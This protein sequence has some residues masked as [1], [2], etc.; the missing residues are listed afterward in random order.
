MNNQL[1]VKPPPSSS[2]PSHAS[3]D[4]KI[5]VDDAPIALPISEKETDGILKDY[6]LGNVADSE[7]KTHVSMIKP[8]R[9]MDIADLNVFYDCYQ[10]VVNRD[11]VADGI[12]SGIA[13]CPDI[14]TSVVVDVDIKVK[15][16]EYDQLCGGAMS[17]N[18]GSDSD[19]YDIEDVKALIGIYIHTLREIVPE[20][21]E[22]SFVAVYL[23]KDPYPIDGCYKNGFHIQFPNI[24][25]PR[26]KQE[27]YLLPRIKEKVKNTKIFSNFKCEEVIDDTVIRNP[28]L[29]YKSRKSASMSPY[30]AESVYIPVKID[31]G[32][33]SKLTG[34]D[35]YKSI[36]VKKPITDLR[37]LCK[38]YDMNM[39]EIKFDK[40]KKIEYYLPRIL[41]INPMGR[42]TLELKP[43]LDN[44][45][46]VC[47]KS[48]DKI[49][50]NPH[51]KR[52][53]KENYDIAR[54]LVPL[55]SRERAIDY[56]K[57]MQVGWALYNIGEGS[58]EFYNLWCQFSKKAESYDESVCYVNWTKMGPR[59][60]T[61]GTLLYYAKY[62]NPEGFKKWQQNQYKES[63]EQSLTAYGHF[64]IAQILWNLD[65]NN[66]V[67]SP[68][69]KKWFYYSDGIWS[70]D[71]E[72]MS[73][74]SK[75]S[76][77]VFDIYKSKNIA[78]GTRMSNESLRDMGNKQV[79][80]VKIMSRLKDSSF[81]VGI[82]KAARELYC[83][84]NFSDELDKNKYL[85]AFK[86]GD[87]YDLKE[88][89]LRKSI[90][91]DLISKCIPH[92]YTEFD[93]DSPEILWIERFLDT[94]FPN[95]AIRKYFMDT[96]CD[97]VQ[98]GNTYKIVGIWSGDGNNGKSIMAKMLEICLG[99]LSVKLPTSIIS[100]KRTQSS[101]A[102][103]E[104]ARIG[105]GVRLCAVQEPERGIYMNTGVVKELSGNDR[106]YARGLFKDGK[107]IDP[108]FNFIIICN[109]L[110]RLENGGDKAIW[111]RM[112]VYPF[113]SIFSTNA[114][115]TYEEQVAAKH[116]PIDEEL[117]EKLSTYAPAFMYH[118]IKHRK[119]RIDAGSKLYTPPD[120]LTATE[121][122]KKNNDSI[123]QFVDE[124]ILKTTDSKYKLSLTEAYEEFQRW[125]K[126]TFP[127]GRICNK[128]DFADHCVNLMGKMTSTRK[129]NRHR[130]KTE[131][132]RIKKEMEE[133]ERM[134]GNGNSDIIPSTTGADSY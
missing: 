134:N 83:H 95:P 75:I 113:E 37:I 101:S 85:L 48:V 106:F 16:T 120:V 18:T 131:Q 32:I 114:P 69:D 35:K 126:N 41:S 55:L 102:T 119:K 15:G 10:D 91:D 30:I 4:T 9:R 112:R 127:N 43:D 84:R 71:A 26:I 76:T 11:V 62:D 36:I 122:Y 128:N 23:R 52:T 6:I 115:A 121:A 45:N 12:V 98:G 57:W 123:R 21:T 47:M 27:I 64:D 88:N 87:V 3:I 80:C 116:F 132:D 89:R 29:M 103:P 42:P 92:P 1:S 68:D 63:V 19:I 104:I 58:S 100:A 51:T 79:A 34:A 22:N 17:E 78:L 40:H 20:A 73:L 44:T 59:N 72:G 96:T 82:M 130:L 110:P 94:L 66:H 33:E 107:E 109:A 117:G 77:K 93:D 99:P 28:W 53:V 90:P 125:F 38:I 2:S 5:N 56:I 39:R 8:K 50:D 67:Y 7:H 24:F 65:G 31:E 49:V 74:L 46:L 86:G 13:E 124:S 60:L 111:N 118:L 129:W 133:L 97:V 81:K 70:H 108:M 54:V 25:I 105:G 61:I 14:Y